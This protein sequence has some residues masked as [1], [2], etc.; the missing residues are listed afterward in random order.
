MKRIFAILCLLLALPLGGCSQSALPTLTVTTLSIGQADCSILCYG[1]YCIVVDCGEDDDGTDI[2]EA[3]RLRN[4]SRINLLVLSHFDKDHIG[5][6]PELLAGIPVD[7][8]LMPGYT[9]SGKRYQALFDALSQAGVTPEILDGT[10]DFTYGNAA[11]TAFTATDLPQSAAQSDNDHSLLLSMR[12][13]EQTLL[14]AGDVEQPAIDC[15]IKAGAPLAADYLKM[16]HHGVFDGGT[17]AL[18]D[19]VQPQIAVL[20]DSKKNPA[21]QATLDALS[22]AGVEYRRCMDGEIVL[23][24]QNGVFSLRKG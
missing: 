9:G 15:L 5:G 19:A 2:L 21:D 12:Y 18:L 4:I 1:S 24:L 22:Q 7:S 23:T 16:P 11:F 20:C 14:F 10:L 17:K 6:A 8:V 13:G 3:L